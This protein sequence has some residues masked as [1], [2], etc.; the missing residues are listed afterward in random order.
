MYISKIT[1]QKKTFE[2][3]RQ[4]N[5]QMKKDK[6]LSTK[7]DTNYVKIKKHEPNLKSGVNS[8][9]LEGYVVSAPLVAPVDLLFNKPGKCALL[10]IQHLFSM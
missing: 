2:K 5:G 3:D 7:H 10:Y 4:Y 1:T 9:E 6:Q 8:G